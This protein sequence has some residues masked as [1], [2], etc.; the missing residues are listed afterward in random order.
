MNV[1]KRGKMKKDQIKLLMNLVK[2]IAI[3]I[4]GY[5]ILSAFNIIK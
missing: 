3:V 5:I 2:I 1:L 4:L